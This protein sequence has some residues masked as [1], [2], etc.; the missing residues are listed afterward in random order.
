[1]SSTRTTRSVQDA[2]DSANKEISGVFR[3]VLDDHGEATEAI[4]R[5][6]GVSSEMLKKYRNGTRLLP[7]YVLRELFMRT[8]DHRVL[9]VLGYQPAAN[10]L[11][12]EKVDKELHRLF[13]LSSQVLRRYDRATDAGSRGGPAIT[14]LE[15]AGIEDAVRQLLELTTTLKHTF[16]QMRQYP[17]RHPLRGD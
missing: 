7:A 4:C 14:P 8:K 13:E 5:E 9:D 10:A 1:M 11:G 15:A 16:Q 2:R 17:P 12:L 3:S 6:V